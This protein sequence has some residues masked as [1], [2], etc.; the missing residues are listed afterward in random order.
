MRIDPCLSS[1]NGEWR[2]PPYLFHRLNREFGPFTVD[3][4]ASEGNALVPRFWTPKDDG[5]RQ[6]WAGETVWCNPPYSTPMQG[7]F[8]K[9]ASLCE[10]DTAVL[11]V[12]ARTDTRAWHDLVMRRASEIRFLRGRLRFSEAEAGAPFPSAVV[13][14]RK[15]GRFGAPLWCRS[16]RPEPGL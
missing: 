3:A 2:T 15:G 5:T 4:A 11:L 1:G 13:V 12:P 9:R 7:R 8:I 6:P 10:A 14:F 16:W